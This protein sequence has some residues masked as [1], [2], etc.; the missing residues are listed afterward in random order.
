MPPGRFVDVESILIV[1]NTSLRA[2]AALYPDGDWDVRRFRPNLFIDVEDD[3][4][5]GFAEDRWQGKTLRVGNVEVRVNNP[6]FRCTMVTRPQPGLERDLD[7]YR[8]LARHHNGNFG[9]WAS[10]QTPGAI[11]V[12]DPVELIG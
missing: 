4:A 11:S 12:D 7:I 10:V 8:T 6:C 5:D 1:T 9:M 2:G 3:D